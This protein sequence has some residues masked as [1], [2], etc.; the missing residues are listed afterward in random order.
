MSYV[1]DT[2]DVLHRDKKRQRLA[3]GESED[4]RKARQRQVANSRQKR[5]QAWMSN[6][7]ED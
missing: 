7:K 1:L 2:E 5:F 3:A 4:K 6:V